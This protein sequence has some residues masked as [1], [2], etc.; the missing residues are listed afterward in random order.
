MKARTEAKVKEVDRV[1]MLRS[2]EVAEIKVRWTK[3]NM[4]KHCIELLI[5]ILHCHNFY[6]LLLIF[7]VALNWIVAWAMISFI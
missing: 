6:F 2:I 4:H 7:K 5:L 1:K 3:K